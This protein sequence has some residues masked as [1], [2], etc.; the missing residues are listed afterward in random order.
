L[1]LLQYVK[2]AAPC[3]ASWQNMTPVDTDPER[4]RF[5]TQCR[6]NVYNLSEMTQPEAEG[7]LRSHEGRLCVRYFQRSDGTILTKD[8]PVG[9]AAVRMN[10]IRRSRSAAALTLLIGV[11]A[12]G[13]SLLKSTKAVPGGS[14]TMGTPISVAEPPQ[15]ALSENLGST[16]LSTE[17]PANSRPP[18]PASS[19]VTEKLGEVAPEPK[20][21][22]KASQTTTSKDKKHTRDAGE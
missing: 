17:L 20:S 22:T 8:C 5:C 15:P 7:L 2:V 3:P 6:M 21:H 19:G 11:G 18:V 10:M 13:A 9:T 16:R 14:V 12:F 4:V 1:P